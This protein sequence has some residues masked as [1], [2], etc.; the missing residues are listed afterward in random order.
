[1]IFCTVQ[2]ICGVD[3]LITRSSYPQFSLCVP[4]HYLPPEERHTI[5][6]SDL[7]IILMLHFLHWNQIFEAYFASQANGVKSSLCLV[8]KIMFLV[9]ISRMDGG[10]RGVAMAKSASWAGAFPPFSCRWF[11]PCRNFSLPWK[12]S[13]WNE[14]KGDL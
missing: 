8:L 3:E 10:C 5:Q 14:E 9:L 1:M 6:I 2:H 13:A 11:C 4:Q 12:F 7:G